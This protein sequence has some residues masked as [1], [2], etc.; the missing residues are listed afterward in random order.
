MSGFD[1]GWLRLRAPFDDAARAPRLASRFAA[2]LGDRAR[3]LDLGAGAGANLRHLAPRLGRRQAWTLVDD[4]PGLLAAA[5]SE[6][7]AWA[8]ARGWG[9][10]G[11]RD[12]GFRLEGDGRTV[13]ARPVI[14]DLA[15]GPDSLPWEAIDGVTASALLD[16]TSAA[17]LDALAERLRARRL[18]ALFALSFDGRLRWRPADPADGLAA[19]GFAAHQSFDKGFGPALGPAAAEHAAKVLKAP[20][21][22][23]ATAASDWRVAASD[24]PMLRAML[25]GVAGAA[26]EALPDEAA[27]IGAWRDRRRGAIERGEASLV[28]GHVDVLAVPEVGHAASWEGPS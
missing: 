20:G 26:A 9:F 27:A 13:V 24:R 23:V 25:D 3:L 17:W 7:R 4:D 1:P 8:A 15:R 18:P 11:D 5:S 22:T 16:L 6:T 10:A 2:F 12:G 21:R 28:V 19:R 14:A